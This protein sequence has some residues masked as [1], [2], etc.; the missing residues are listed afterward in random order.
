MG[1]VGLGLMADAMGWEHSHTS[2]QLIQL[3]YL[4]LGRPIIG[5]VVI[6]QQQ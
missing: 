2:H 4:T 5:D 6:L 3:E 1:C